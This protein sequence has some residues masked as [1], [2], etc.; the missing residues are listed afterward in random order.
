MSKLL[1]DNKKE[2]KLSGIQTNTIL[3]NFYY[4][5]DTEDNK[6]KPLNGIPKGGILHLVGTNG[7]GK[8][9]LAAN[10][11][12]N[13]IQKQKLLYI[14]TE[15]IAPLVYSKIKERCKILGLEF[16]ENN[17][18]IFDLASNTEALYDIQI[19]FNEIINLKQR[20]EFVIIDSLTAF[21]EN[22]ENKAR[23]IVRR[24]YNFFSKSGI[25]GIFISQKRSSHEENTSEAAGG[26][27]VAH[28]LDSTIVLIK[29]VIQNK[30]E[31]QEY[32]AIRGKMV[33]LI[34]VDD[35][36]LSIHSTQE[37]IIK[38]NEKGIFEVIG[39]REVV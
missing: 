33:R 4:Y 23:T 6:I 17:L 21:Y 15:V 38:I 3:D 28:I 18:F 34:R 2:Y 22:L 35:C 26:Y 8:S 14:S 1:F 10:I 29:K 24:I 7:T 37:Y 25:T 11:T 20:I 36:R 32:K 13:I 5:Y 30:W 19:L 31:E 27:A 9:L 12:A 39:K 16:K